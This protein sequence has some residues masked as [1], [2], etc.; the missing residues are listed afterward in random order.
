MIITISSTT[1]PTPAPTPPPIIA[2]VFAFAS[3][4][5]EPKNYQ[6]IKLIR[7]PYLDWFFTKIYSAWILP[8]S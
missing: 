4:A 1:A 3:R 8:K 5:G 2:A 7:L 6:K